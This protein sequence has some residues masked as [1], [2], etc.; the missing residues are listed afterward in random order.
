M[1]KSRVGTLN[2]RRAKFSL[3]KDEIFWETIFRDIGIEQKWHLFKDTFLRAREL[4]I[5]Q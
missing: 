4:S 3:F 2:F 5:L 1:A